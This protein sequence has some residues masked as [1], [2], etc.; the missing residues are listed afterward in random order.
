MSLA[1]Y[2]RDRVNPQM[3]V[4]SLSVA[5]LHRNDTKDIP[6]PQLNEIFPDMF[7]KGSIFPRA[8]EVA[9]VA[10]P[11]DRVSYFQNI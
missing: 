7:F 6:I 2:T 8:R 1:A 3:W 11:S 5:L 10:E 9:N 4:Y